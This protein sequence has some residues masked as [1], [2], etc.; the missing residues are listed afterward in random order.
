VQFG[1]TPEVPACTLRLTPVVAASNETE[2]KR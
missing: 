2:A 1:F